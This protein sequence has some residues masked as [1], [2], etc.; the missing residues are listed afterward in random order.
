MV[1]EQKTV[2][3]LAQRLANSDTASG[4]PVSYSA[5]HRTVT[6][7]PMHKRACTLLSNSNKAVAYSRADQTCHSANINALKQA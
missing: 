4:Q 7:F 1:V 2:A 3:G 5:W 6:R